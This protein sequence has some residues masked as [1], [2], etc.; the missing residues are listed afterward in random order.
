MIK[1]LNWYLES[2]WKISLALILSASI[3]LDSLLFNVPLIIAISDFIILL[4]LIEP[5]IN[6]LRILINKDKKE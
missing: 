5:N 6:C 2:C 3:I 4:I 1:N